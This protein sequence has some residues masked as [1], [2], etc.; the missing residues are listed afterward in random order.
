[1]NDDGQP[2]K[3]IEVEQPSSDQRP[4]WQPLVPYLVVLGLAACMALVV[5]AYLWSNRDEIYRIITTTPV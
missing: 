5:A 1:M 3:T 4:S 2:G